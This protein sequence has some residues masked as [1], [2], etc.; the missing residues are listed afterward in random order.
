MLILKE[1]GDKQHFYQFVGSNWVIEIFLKKREHQKKGEIKQK[2]EA[3]LY[4][5]YWGFKKI[6]FALFTYVLG[7]ILQNGTKYIQ[8]LI[9][10]FKNHM[11]NL[12]FRQAVK[13]P[14]NY[15]YLKLLS[16]TQVKIH[17]ITYVIF[18][19]IRNFHD[20][21]PLYSF[22]SNITYFVQKQFIKVQ[23]FR[24][25]TTHVKVR[26][27]LHV[28]FQT[29]S[30]FFFKVQIFFSVMRNNYSVLFELKLFMLFTKVVLH[31]SANFQTC[32][33]SH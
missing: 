27:I 2:I 20:T 24:H 23:I 9:P 13:S 32:H 10:S 14:K 22:S 12:D 17:Q 6:P 21:T 26:Q 1:Q 31:Q 30:H 3:S 18:E 7:K 25:C 11:M 15:Y 33:R 29:K 5:L 28:I 4:T 19:T 8:K 16:S